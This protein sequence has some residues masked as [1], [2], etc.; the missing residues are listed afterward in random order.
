MLYLEFVFSKFPQFCNSPR[1]HVLFIK[2]FSALSVVSAV[3]TVYDSLPQD[4][5][6]ASI[7]QI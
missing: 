5:G 4:V 2:C 6:Q 1:G 7:L 3:L